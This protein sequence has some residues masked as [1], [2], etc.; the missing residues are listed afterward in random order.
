LSQGK[1]PDSL[2]FF[3]ELFVEPAHE[4][5]DVAFRDIETNQGLKI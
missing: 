3:A 5:V 4:V 1:T 2:P